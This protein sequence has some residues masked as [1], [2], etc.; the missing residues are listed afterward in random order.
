[1][2]D[3]AAHSEHCSSSSSS[4]S[5]SAAV[6]WRHPLKVRE[7]ESAAAVS[8]TPLQQTTTTADKGA[9][10]AVFGFHQCDKHTVLVNGAAVIH[11]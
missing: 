10:A 6:L 2:T 3:A 5:T 1:M 9:T 7:N 4:S 8:E 11:F